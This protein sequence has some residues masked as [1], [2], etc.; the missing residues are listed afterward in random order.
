MGCPPRP[1]HRGGQDPPDPPMIYATAYSIHEWN[2]STEKT[3]G[4]T[5]MPWSNSRHHK[6]AVN[7]FWFSLGLCMHTEA[8][9]GSATII[10]TKSATHECKNDIVQKTHK[11]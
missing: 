1:E 11:I 7:I 6:V 5:A 2:D 8:S 9:K 4:Y 10:V 3:Y